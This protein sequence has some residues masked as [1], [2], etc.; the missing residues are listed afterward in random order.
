MSNVRTHIELISRSLINA[1]RRR[2]VVSL[3]L[4]LFC[5][6]AGVRLVSI[7]AAGSTSKG[8]ISPNPPSGLIVTVVSST[9]LRL[10][11]QDNS[12]NETSFSIYRCQGASC[13]PFGSIASVGVD[14]TTFT[15]TGLLGGTTYGYYVIAVGKGG[16]VSPASNTAWATTSSAPSPTPTPTPIPTPTPT[17][18]PTPTPTPTPTPIP[19]APANL[20]ATA[21]STSQINLAWTDMSGNE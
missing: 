16:R 4:L 14:T 15:N 1:G 10:Q 20:T 18:I 3:S 11:W 5:L 6:A 9:S 21:M 13:T 7:E 19:I 17:P 8:F 12:S 2:R